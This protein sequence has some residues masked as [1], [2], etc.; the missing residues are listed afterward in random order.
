MQTTQVPHS[1]KQYVNIAG[2]DVERSLLGSLQVG[3]HLL[4]EMNGKRLYSDNPIAA[5]YAWTIIEMT[6]AVIIVEHPRGDRMILPMANLAK[7]DSES[8]A[9]FVLTTN[10]PQCPVIYVILQLISHKSDTEGMR[11][12]KYKWWFQE[13]DYKELFEDPI[14]KRGLMEK[15]GEFFKTFQDHGWGNKSVKRFALRANIRTDTIRAFIHG[16]WEEINDLP[17]DSLLSIAREIEWL[18]TRIALSGHIQHDFSRIAE[19]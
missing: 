14:L 3:D 17:V 6:E 1:E 19:K 4:I 15:W 13:E 16:A 9:V 18:P 12:S 7:G 11:K 5:A 2:P 10:N 8:P